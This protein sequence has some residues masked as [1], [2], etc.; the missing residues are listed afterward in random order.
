M[1]NQRFV[2]ATGVKQGIGKDGEEAR[3]QGRFR[4]LPLLVNAFGDAGDGSVVPGEDGGR[5]ERRRAEGV[6]DEVTNQVGLGT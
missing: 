2:V 6:A 4:H 5:E 3:V 1:S